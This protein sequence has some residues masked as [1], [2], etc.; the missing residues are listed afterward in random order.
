VASAS[1]R[2]SPVAGSSE[3]QSP[4]TARLRDAAVTIEKKSSLGRGDRY[5]T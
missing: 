4:V 5:R 1:D 3:R 2:R